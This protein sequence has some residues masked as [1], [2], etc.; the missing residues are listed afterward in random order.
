MSGRN[1]LTGGTG[2]LD[3][4]GHTDRGTGAL[5]RKGRTDK[6]DGGT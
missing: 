6:E 1:I 3:R 2:V 5:D 4:K